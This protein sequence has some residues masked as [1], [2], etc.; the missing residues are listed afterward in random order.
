MNTG[1]PLASPL[2]GALKRFVRFKRSMGILYH[3][4]ERHMRDLDRLL[5]DRLS[6]RAP[7][8]T[9]AIIRDFVTRRGTESESTRSHRLT[10]IREFCRFRS[11][12]DSRT[13]VP[14]RG[15]LPIRRPTFVPRVLSLAEG[16]SLLSAC[17]S[18]PGARCS[19]LRGVVKGTALA[20][21]YLTGLRVGEALG[22]SIEDVELASASLHI[23]RA[24]FGKSR[25]VP[26]AADLNEK[27]RS[28]RA[29]VDRR[30][31]TRDSKAPF[32]PGRQGAPCS[33]SALTATF[34]EALASAGIR[35]DPQGRWPRIHDLRHTF[36]VHRLILWCRQNE[37]L[38]AKLPVLA[39]YL[40]H[41]GLASSQRYLRV[42]E[43][44]LAE[45]TRRHQ[46]KFGHL[47]TE[48]P[49]P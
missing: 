39:V 38:G 45:I 44:L 14:P 49:R 9:L 30:L 25:L 16:R 48:R 11:S 3:D 40:G 28:C 20:L 41:V 2:A 1:V 6:P 13:V 22:L 47:I 46:A 18:F 19:P 17:M 27:L 10:F 12:E 24:K 35:R 37:N 23:R 32:F 36:A 4:A 8:I 15:L 29:A 33:R 34:R 5:G 21:L 42:T 31:G 26:I 43:D 7:S